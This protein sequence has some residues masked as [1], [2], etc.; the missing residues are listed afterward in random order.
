MC[1]LIPGFKETNNIFKTEVK[2]HPS[3]Q[4]NANKENHN[5]NHQTPIR[6]LFLVGPF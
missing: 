1:F 5:H 4:A 2:K 3:L 6:V